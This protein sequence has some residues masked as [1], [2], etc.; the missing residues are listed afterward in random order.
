MSVQ[1]A[2]ALFLIVAG[3]VFIPLLFIVSQLQDI[4]AELRKLNKQGKP[5]LIRVNEKD[6]GENAWDS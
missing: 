6:Q 2:L 4:L 1:P 5:V 3:M